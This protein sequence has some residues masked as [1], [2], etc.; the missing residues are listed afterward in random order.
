MSEGNEPLTFYYMRP[1]GDAGAVTP[2][3]SE[4][5]V[6]KLVRGEEGHHGKGGLWGAWRRGGAGRGEKRVHPPAPHLLAW[7]GAGSLPVWA[8]RG[9]GGGPAAGGVSPW[10]C[11]GLVPPR[12]AHGNGCCSCAAVRLSRASRRQARG[13]LPRP[14]N[15]KGLGRS[16]SAGL[17]PGGSSGA[18][19][20]AHAHQP[21]SGSSRE[22]GG[23]GWMVQNEGTSIID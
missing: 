5:T 21:P 23:A 22:L 17:C 11:A 13:G 20:R 18:A 19:H 12:S 16:P 10:H 15:L 3:M 1:L 9:A 4:R 6:P 14:P 2:A 8:S 7:P